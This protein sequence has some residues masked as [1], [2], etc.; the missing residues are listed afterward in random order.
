MTNKNAGKATS[1]NGSIDAR[2]QTKRVFDYIAE[3]DA[4]E[5]VFGSDFADVGRCEYI[6][7]NER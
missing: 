3:L 1:F 7:T 4:K 2:Q 5:M 6:D